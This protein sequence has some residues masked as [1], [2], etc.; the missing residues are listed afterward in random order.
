MRLHMHQGL[1]SIAA[2]HGRGPRR[3]PPDGA[4]GGR[5]R[6][7][8]VLTLSAVLAMAGGLVVRTASPA[9]PVR[10]PPFDPGPLVGAVAG[11]RT[12]MAKPT[13]LLYVDD[14]CPWCAEELGR[15]RDAVGP[16]PRAVLPTVVLSPRSDARGGHV[17]LVL[18]SGVVHDRDGSIARALGVRA[19]PFRAILSACG[20]VTAVHQ[21][22]TTAPE[23]RSLLDSLAS[24]KEN[25][26][27]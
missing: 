24:L 13:I 18:R 9:S 17:P 6:L 15:W 8:A 21:G 3:A 7:V 16:R 14:H 26:C 23:I 4:G 5:S 1:L 20:H 10:E 27:P 2:F 22:L 25:P 12:E 19:V 11:I